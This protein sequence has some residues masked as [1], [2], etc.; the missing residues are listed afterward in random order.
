MNQINQLIVNLE[1][2][3]E[4]YWEAIDNNESPDD[5]V[6]YIANELIDLGVGGI[7]IPTM[8]GRLKWFSLEDM[9]F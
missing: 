3:M 2:A 6:Y 5:S 4:E 8:Q 9:A 7:L 1:T